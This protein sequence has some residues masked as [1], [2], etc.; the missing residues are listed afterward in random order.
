MFTMFTYKSVMLMCIY[1]MLASYIYRA[2]IYKKKNTNEFVAYKMKTR[3]GIAY[4]TVRP[5]S[6]KR[7]LSIVG[8]IFILTLL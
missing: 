3:K 2:Y 5:K 4:L 6:V 8:T 7:Y 1:I